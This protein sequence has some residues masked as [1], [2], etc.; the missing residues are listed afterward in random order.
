MK[1]LAELA[2]TNGVQ[3]GVHAIGDRANRESLDI[4]EA[5]FKAALRLS[6]DQWAE[7]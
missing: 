1:A 5:T 7:F 4:F 6:L 2:A 3:L